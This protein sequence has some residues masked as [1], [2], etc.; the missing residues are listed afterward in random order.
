VWQTI[1]HEVLHGIADALKMKLN[2]KDMHDELDILALAIT[3]VFY[4]NGWIKT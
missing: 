2:K 4:R 3:D 1:I